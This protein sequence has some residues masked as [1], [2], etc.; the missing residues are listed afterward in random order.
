[1]QTPFGLRAL[2]LGVALALV[3][4]Q[5]TRAQAV[6]KDAPAQSES[7]AVAEVV[8][9]YGAALASGD[10]T[11]ALALLAP[12]AVVLESGSVETREEYRGHHLPADIAFAR[13][14]RSEDSPVRVTVLGD[15]AWAWST[16]TTQ[17]EYR[18]RAIN[19]ASA[20]LMVLSRGADGRWLIR[21]IHWS[22]R[23]RRSA[24]TG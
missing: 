21:A 5:T 19:N 10:S 8:R 3:V 1:M 7:T 2:A 23:A 6:T 24:G 22:S 9:R 15:A 4:P 17:G 12:D 20:E 11:A 16:S 14:V 13:A 18:G